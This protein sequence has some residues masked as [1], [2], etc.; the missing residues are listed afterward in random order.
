MS[1]HP[2]PIVCD[3]TVVLNLGHR[4]RLDAL[5]GHLRK[6]RKLY[7]TPEVTHEVA[8]NDPAFYSTFLSLHFDAVSEPVI[9]WPKLSEVAGQGLN[10]GEMSVLAACQVHGWVAGIDELGGR[11]AATALGLKL[12]GT[13]GMLAHAV[14]EKWMDD[15]EALEAIVRLRQAGFHCPKV[16]ANDDFQEYMNRLR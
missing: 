5:A 12:M 3:T 11:R 8:R 10:A 16:L 1:K 14:E 15:E 4:G 9:G 6:E 13:L 7:V 2:T